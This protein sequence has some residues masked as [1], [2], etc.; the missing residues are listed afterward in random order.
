MKSIWSEIYLEIYLEIF[1]FMGPLGRFFILQADLDQTHL[2]CML[3]FY[4]YYSFIYGRDVFV[5]MG[6]LVLGL[7]PLG[8]L[9]QR[10]SCRDQT[11]LPCLALIEQISQ[12]RYAAVI[13]AEIIL[14]K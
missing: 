12:G 9:P 1:V 10:T 4:L 14:V 3:F 6:L 7:L 11:H 5:L 2:P 8:R 13:T